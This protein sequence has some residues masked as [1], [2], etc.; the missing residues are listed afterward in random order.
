VSFCLTSAASESQSLPFSKQKSEERKGG[1]RLLQRR[2]LAG[3][4]LMNL[5]GF[6]GFGQWMG[7]R[8]RRLPEQLGKRS[9]G[10]KD[11]RIGAENGVGKVRGGRLA[12]AAAENSRHSPPFIHSANRFEFGRQRD[13]RGRWRGSGRRS[14][15]RRRW[16]SGWW[17]MGMEKD[18]EKADEPGENGQNSR[19]VLK[20]RKDLTKLERGSEMWFCWWR[21]GSKT[22]IKQQRSKKK[23]LEWWW[24]KLGGDCWWEAVEICWRKSNNQSTLQDGWLLVEWKLLMRCITGEGWL[25]FLL[26]LL[27]HWV[28]FFW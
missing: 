15:G 18:G 27:A 11:R 6:G 24:Y 25:P 17:E 13:G 7:W 12:A 19:T 28:L 8:R 26:F 5:M 10:R 2:S 14:L 4:L 9:K 16:R 22:I 21:R 23:K 1:G 3:W 20:K